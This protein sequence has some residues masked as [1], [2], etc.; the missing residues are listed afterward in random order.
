MLFPYHEMYAQNPG[1][2]PS[3]LSLKNALAISLGNSSK[4]SIGK[5]K[6]LEKQSI[7]LERRSV[8]LPRLSLNI[9]D[10]DATINL[11]AQG[12]SFPGAPDKIGPFSTFDA[13]LTFNETLLN[14]NLLNQFYAADEDT[15]VSE[16]ELSQTE[17]DLLYQT[18]I[19]FLSALRTE[20]SVLA[21]QANVNL[22]EELLHFAEHQ[23]ETGVGTILDVTRA[24]VKLAEDRQRLIATMTQKNDAILALQKQLG[25]QQGD[26]LSLDHQYLPDQDFPDLKE[27]LQTALSKRKELTI[28]S[29]KERV[30]E[31]QF[32]AASGE[33]YPSVNFFAD[34]GEIGNGISD[35]FPTQTIGITLNFPLYDGKTREAHEQTI[36]SQL[37]QE[38][39]KTRDTALQVELDV[40]QI[41]N[42]LNAVK[43]QLEVAEERLS[44]AENELKL[45]EH[46]FENGIGTHIELIKSQ[47]SLT[48]SREGLVDAQFQVRAGILKFFYVTGQMEEFFQRL[49]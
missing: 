44:L 23:K 35:A 31:I 7:R 43:K 14:L 33:K 47:T 38:R 45:A 3:P 2:A 12:I 24:R 41:Y 36:M 49:P 30:K 13:R 15:K 40:R 26:I 10:R 29:Q 22:S 34:Y 11:K 17:S 16:L 21:D 32:K 1:E 42:D 27:G 9:S 4:V 19:L 6:I 25:V 39:S 20:A 46:R 28:Q 8:F 48:D 5:E 37:R 18:T